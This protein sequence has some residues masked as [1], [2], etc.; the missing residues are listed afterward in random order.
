M[1]TRASLTPSVSFPLTAAEPG[2]HQIVPMLPAAVKRQ[3]PVCTGNCGQAT[4]RL[5]RSS[6]RADNEGRTTLAYGASHAPEGGVRA[7]GDRPVT[8]TAPGLK[9][10]D[11]SVR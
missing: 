10:E 6:A 2:M 5:N 11:V 7:G 8:A 3:P 4:N 9:V 1:R